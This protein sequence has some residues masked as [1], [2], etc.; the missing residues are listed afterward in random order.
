[1]LVSPDSYNHY[2]LIAGVITLLSALVPNVLR[3]KHLTPPIIYLAIGALAYFAGTDYTNLDIL[4]HKDIIKHVSEF[5][6]IIAL[7]NAGLKISKPFSWQTWKY[8]VLLLGVTMPMTIVAVSLTGYWLLNFMPATALLFG[9]L[10]APTDPVLASDLQTTQPSKKDLSKIRLSLTSEA[11][12]NDGLAFP[13]TFL[14]I[15]MSAKGADLSSWMVEWF[16]VEV[17]YKITAAVIIGFLTGWL[18]HRL[19]FKFTDKTHH[20]NISRGILSLSL[21]LIPYALTEFA[22]AY[23]FIAVFVAAC[24]FSNSETQA[25]HMDSLH[26]FT[27]E[28]ERIFVT[29][30]FLIIGIYVCANFKNLVDPY[31]IATALLIIFIIRPLGGWIALSRTDLSRYEKIV[32]SFYGIRGIGSLFYLVYA[33]QET[34]FENVAKLIQVTVATIV[35]SVLIHGSTSRWAQKRLNSIEHK[36]RVDQL[37]DQ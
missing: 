34:S 32:L 33:L 4:Q 2:I 18:L 20:S 21:T 27:E 16:L 26:D 28:I 8:T 7:V 25:K 12:L 36:R 35:L 24:V 1:M 37:A 9:A 17:L 11:G 10:I 5:V 15:Y 3:N 29:F 13:F 23:G 22:H 14:A 30:I 31:I 6:V 19:I